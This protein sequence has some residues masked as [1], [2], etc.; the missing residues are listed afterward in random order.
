MNEEQDAMRKAD[1]CVYVSDI[2]KVSKEFDWIPFI[3]IGSGY[4]KIHNWV[5][6]NKRILQEIY[7]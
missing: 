2:R 4:H 1:H 7:Q 3:D 6:Y 5:K